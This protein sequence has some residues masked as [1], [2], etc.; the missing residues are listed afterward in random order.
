MGK[1]EEEEESTGEKGIKL[2]RG[3]ETFEGPEKRPPNTVGRRAEVA[4]GRG[5]ASLMDGQLP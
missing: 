4:K 2:G 5:A 1:G 3:G